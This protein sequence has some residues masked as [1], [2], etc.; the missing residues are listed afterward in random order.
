LLS[1]DD[2]LPQIN[3]LQREFEDAVKTGIIVDFSF[4]GTIEEKIVEEINKKFLSRTFYTNIPSVQANK[5]NIILIYGSWM[6]DSRTGN[7][8]FSKTTAEILFENGKLK[9]ESYVYILRSPRENEDEIWTGDITRTSD[10]LSFLGVR[11]DSILFCRLC[12]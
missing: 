7:Y 1:T 8:K 2:S 4:Y 10:G 12:F 5:K 9:S 6:R 3:N 11:C